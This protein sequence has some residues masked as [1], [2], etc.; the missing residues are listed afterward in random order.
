[1]VLPMKLLS[2]DKLE[3][4]YVVSENI[5]TLDDRLVLP[6]G[7][8]LD[9]KDIERIKSFS[10]YNIFVEDKKKDV[11]P[12]KADKP[13]EEMSYSEKLKTSEEFIKFKQHIEENAEKLEESFK[14]IANDT[15]Q[16][17]V[18]K[19]TE[20]VYH[21][22]VEAGGTAGIFDMLHNL[23][24]SS[25]T[26]YMHSLNVSL[27]S[28]TIAS[29]MKL[30]DDDIQLATAG[31]LLHDIGKTLMPPELL[32]KNMVLTE[33]EERTMK[34]HVI[35]GYDL[36]K[37][38]PINQHIKNCV[39]MHHE[40]RDGTGYPFHLRGEQ[41]DEIASI[42]T[43]ANIY[44]DLTAK[45]PYRNAVCPFTVIEQFESYGLYKYDADVIMTFLSNIVNTFIANRVLLS[46]G[47]SGD[48][49]FI[50]PEHLSKP[51]VK[52]GEQYIDLAKKREISIIAVI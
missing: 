22:F 33:Y 12:K 31:G 37:D 38:K 28:N 27:I 5:Y 18:D 32:N 23:R 52:C 25:D 1:M 11:E 41:I 45:K 9:E 14:M 43:V 4:G 44:D 48:I 50:N 47:Q 51:V 2:V 29:W 17:D 8:V 30:S 24:D 3:P 13:A 39:L 15:I 40:L 7:T 16:L 19:L 6:K 20:P 10:L 21:L 26:V 42:V 49:I 34:E 36:V 46:T 35:K